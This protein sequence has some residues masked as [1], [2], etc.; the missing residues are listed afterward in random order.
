M[1]YYGPKEDPV[2]ST[3][4]IVFFV[5]TVTLFFAN[6]LFVSIHGLACIKKRVPRL[7]PYAL[8]MPF[9]WVLISIGAWKGLIQLFTNPFHWE[10]TMHGL[11]GPGASPDSSG[12][13]GV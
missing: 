2:W 11:S 9:Y 1:V 8:L 10:K 5:I 13:G 7:L 12:K 6:F 3:L 4:S